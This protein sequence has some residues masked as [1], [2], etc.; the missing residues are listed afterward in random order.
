MMMLNAA[1]IA[2]H[3]LAAAVWV[4]GMVFAYTVLRPSVDVMEAPHKMT[5]LAAV[6]RRFFVWVWH[7]VIV[8]PVTG[9]VMMFALYNGFAGSGGHIHLM[10]GLAWVM[11][12]LFLYM[13]LGPYPAFRRAVTAADWADAAR[14]L[15]RIRRI[16]GINLVL[17]VI[18][19]VAGS[20]GRFL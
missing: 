3:A 17:G 16:I 19:V 10:Q 14:H 4:G 5:L 20:A 9:Y 8:L 15:P 6:F 2:L 1:L 18:T 12:A 11:T 13:V 7:A